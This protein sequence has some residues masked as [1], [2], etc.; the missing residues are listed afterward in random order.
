MC[1]CAVSPRPL[2][3]KVRTG[4]GVIITGLQATDPWG[5][6]ILYSV[7]VAMLPAEAGRLIASPPNGFV[8]FYSG[9]PLGNAF[10]ITSFGPNC[11]L[12]GG[13]DITLAMSVTETRGVLLLN[14]QGAD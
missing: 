6:L 4:L 2:E 12:G 5:T 13:D 7:G 3:L 8:G 9:S 10:T 11:V 14:Y 1:R